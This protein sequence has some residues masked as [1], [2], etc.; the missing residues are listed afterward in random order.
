MD[1]TPKAMHGNMQ[2]RGDVH[3]AVRIADCKL[4]TGKT[5]KDSKLFIRPVK[6]EGSNQRTESRSPYIQDFTASGTL[7]VDEFYISCDELKRLLETGGRAAG[8]GSARIMGFG[9]FTVSQWEQRP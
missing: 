5:L 2:N 1:I 8:I 4:L 3:A 9:R 6:L 7:L